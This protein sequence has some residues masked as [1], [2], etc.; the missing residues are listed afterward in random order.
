VSG[1]FG[2]G[3]GDWSEDNSRHQMS[4]TKLLANPVWGQAEVIGIAGGYGM[5]AFR[6]ADAVYVVGCAVTMQQGQAPSCQQGLSW[7]NNANK[8]IEVQL[9]N[10]SFAA[11][12][13][14]VGGNYLCAKNQQNHFYCLGS[15]TPGV[16]MG[17][18]NNSGGVNW[19]RAKLQTNGN[20]L[21]Q[22]V[23]RLFAGAKGLNC[24]NH[25]NRIQCLGVNQN[26][27]LMLSQIR[28]NQGAPIVFN[29]P[30]RD[31]AVGESVGCF[32]D[33]GGC[34]QCFG[35][36]F[37]GQRGNGSRCD[38]CN[39]PPNF[40]R[41]TPITAFCDGENRLGGGNITNVVVGATHACASTANGADVWCWGKTNEGQAGI[42]NQNLTHCTCPVEIAYDV[43]N[44]NQNQ[45]SC[46]QEC[47]NG[48]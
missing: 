2:L 38:G 36:N 30:L 13:F 34:V 44:E 3:H 17:R 46:P 16:A 37:E 7:A 8:P 47:Q 12:D 40:D 6:T 43:W 42:I 24:T 28:N 4:V 29:N 25:N 27:Q 23:D 9:N 39:N 32:V 35:S 41:A 15:N 11:V 18:Q 48:N 45:P 5:S 26:N 14:T 1:G 19:W 22:S 33:H 10:D 21:D 20:W 31:L